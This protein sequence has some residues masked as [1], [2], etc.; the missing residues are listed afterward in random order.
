MI[1]VLVLVSALIIIS[2]LQTLEKTFVGAIWPIVSREDDGGCQHY[3]E[4]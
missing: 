1:G 4:Q 3:G 2:P